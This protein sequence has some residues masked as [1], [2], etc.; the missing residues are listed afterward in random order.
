MNVDGVVHADVSFDDAA[1]MVT[2]RPDRVRGDDLTRAV[3][4]AGFEAQV[5]ED[6]SNDPPGAART[7]ME[8]P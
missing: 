1:A 8:Q 5:M 3:Q 6:G 2:F 4:E 7:S